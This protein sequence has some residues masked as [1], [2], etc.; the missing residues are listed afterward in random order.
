MNFQSIAET[1]EKDNGLWLRG[2]ILRGAEK[3]QVIHG[4]M[5]TNI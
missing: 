4:A 3:G 1:I 5:A 2:I